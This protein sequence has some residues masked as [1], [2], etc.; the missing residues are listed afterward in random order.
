MAVNRLVASLE[1]LRNYLNI[2]P[3]TVAF[4]LYCNATDA[5][6][7]TVQ[8]A[9]NK[10]ILTIVGGDDAAV[11]TLD[12]DESNPS[13]TTFDTFGEMVDYIDA[14]DGWW[15]FLYAS[16]TGDVLTLADVPS[17]DVLGLSKLIFLGTTND[18]FKTNRLN[19]ELQFV[20]EG[21]TVSFERYMK[22][23]LDTQEIT[24]YYDGPDDFE[25]ILK[26][27][28]ISAIDSIYYDINW[29]WASNTLIDSDNY[30][31]EPESG[32]VLYNSGKFF[33]GRRSIKITYTY[34]WTIIPEDIRLEG[35]KLSAIEYLRSV[36][37]DQRIGI[38]QQTKRSTQ[39]DSK[40]TTYVVKAMPDDTR[41]V[42]QR[43]KRT[44]I[45]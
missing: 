42:L 23:K 18:Q 2:T 33:G 10:L 3:S 44:I 25:L 7:A 12:Y 35:V 31:F 8:I 27:Y 16:S 5:T 17:T 43:Y 11:Y 30:T 38:V 41:D 26:N 39:V 15:A 20:L 19:D 32:I 24:E 21:V 22:R 37:G 6:T 4:S 9:G 40:T 45:V 36:I 28:P 1:E 29:E 34:G 14:L 13:R